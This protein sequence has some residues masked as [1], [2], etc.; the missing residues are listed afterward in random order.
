M[1]NRFSIASYSFHGLHKI[2]AMN[3]IQYFETVKYRYNMDTADIW[4]GMLDR[5]DDDYLR[6]VKQQMD[7]RGLTLVNLCCDGANI[8]SEA[9]EDRARCEAH[10]QECLRAAE[11][12]GALTVRMDLGIPEATAS[13]EQ[14]ERSAAQFDAYCQQAARFGA[15]MG[16]ENHWGASTNVVVMRKLFE[17]VKASNFGLL[18]HLGNWRQTEDVDEDK[19]RAYDLEFASK[20]MHMHMHYEACLD[21]DAQFPALAAAGYKGSWSVESHKGFNEYNNVAF[22]LAQVKRVLSPLVYGERA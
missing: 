2:G 8:W 13:D 5:F 3:I 12:L 4:N 16:P 10:A 15:M 18:L 9:D 20:A 14:I 19:A 11:I 6:L 7:E 1:S 17:G 22:Q 21:A